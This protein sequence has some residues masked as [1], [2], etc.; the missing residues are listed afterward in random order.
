VSRFFAGT[1]AFRA[2]GLRLRRRRAPSPEAAPGPPPVTEPPPVAGRAPA[3]VGTAATAGGRFLAA[4]G[5]RL[6][7]GLRDAG[8]A[9]LELD[10]SIRR[11]LAVVAAAVLAVVAFVVLAVPA[12]P[13]QYPGGDACPPP[14]HAAKLV[15]ADALAY[16]HFD[17]DSS[18]DRYQLAAD[19]LSRVPI[20]SAQ[21]IDGLLAGLPG[22]AASTVGFDRTVRPWLG[23]EAALALL[24]SGGTPEVVELLAIHGTA[25]A[26][27]YQRS[28]EG[29]GARTTTYRATSIEVGRGGI[30]SAIV[31]GFLVIGTPAGTR[32]VVDTATGAK[33]ATALSG[34]DSAVQIRGLLPAQRVADAYLSP[35]G[36]RAIAGRPTGL[37]SQ[38]APFVAPGATRGV[39]IGLVAGDGSL[40][41]EIRSALDPKRVKARP[42]FFAAFPQFEAT[43][44]DHL[45][46]DTLAYLGI[47]EPG[48][49]IASLLSQASTEEPGLARATSALLQRL[50]KAAHLALRRDLL[51]ALGAEAAL[52]L[53]P[54]PAPPANR[55]AA[56][57][58][59]QSQTAPIPGLTEP[60]ARPPRPGVAGSPYFLYVGG[61]IDSKKARPALARLQTPVARALSGGAGPSGIRS[62]TV[63]GVSAQSLPV[64]PTFDLTYAIVGGRLLVA[65]D[66]R[67]VAAVARG[68]GGLSSSAPYQDATS[69]FPDSPSLLAYLDLRGLVALGE[70]AGLAESPAYGTFAA[71]I[72]RLRS[73]AVS[74]SAAPDSLATDA[75]LDIGSA[76]AEPGTA[77]T[78]AAP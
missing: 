1:E 29:P 36:V 77:G 34:S 25:G 71:D 6:V 51:P 54:A 3:A 49:V 53:E 18:D 28:F 9:W 65:T 19:E 45:P 31:N 58:S 2:L 20:L 66:S 12:L 24:P 42:G 16:V 27:R 26:K 13:C 61:G 15:P 73:L 44:A 10:A 47:G 17:V 39:A 7:D 5:Y 68:D 38:L 35:G 43:L 21:V 4:I 69:G 32:V 33:G 52:A 46:T 30:A 56:N 23:S 64:S 76:A 48:R 50:R 62:R 70:A 75:R 40:E 8:D 22:N 41:L 57:R 11:W 55:P 67:G 63:A 60:N 74:V 59:Q 72:H 78:G 14:D 37:L